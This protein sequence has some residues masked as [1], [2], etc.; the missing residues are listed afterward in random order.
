MRHDGAARVHEA[1]ALLGHPITGV[2]GALGEELC[3]LDEMLADS[4]EVTVL[5]LE[6]LAGEPQ[7]EIGAGAEGHGI[8]DGLEA[9]GAA[10][11]DVDGLVGGRGGHRVEQ[12][13]EGLDGDD[14][15]GQVGVIGQELVIFCDN[16]EA[17]GRGGCGAEGQIRC[18]RCARSVS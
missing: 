2:D 1:P 13:N 5:L 15:L 6:H 11:E 7:E 18:R 4:L 8:A 12:G 9:L 14:G 10:L 3:V 17:I 16:I